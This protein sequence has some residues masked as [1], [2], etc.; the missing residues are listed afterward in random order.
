MGQ[1]FHNL[2]GKIEAITSAWLTPSAPT[3]T[4]VLMGEP[5]DDVARPCVICAAQDIPE[6]RIKDSGI[7]DVV[8]DVI[9]QGN[10]DGD[11]AAAAQQILVAVILDRMRQ[12]DIV[13]S[14]S[15]PTDDLHVYD[16]AFVSGIK[17]VNSEKR[18]L[19]HTSVWKFTCQP[20]EYGS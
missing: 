14:I 5:A 15:G 4:K 2:L 11:G 1:P 16:I 13:A 6:E 12:D 17:S 7:Y 19:I 20:S 10:A 18:L 3:G 8:L 9:V